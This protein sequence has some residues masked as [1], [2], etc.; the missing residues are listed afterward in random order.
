MQLYPATGLSNKKLRETRWM[1]A[2]ESDGKRVRVTVSF[3]SHV[4]TPPLSPPST[5]RQ[6]RRRVLRVLGTLAPL[7]SLKGKFLPSW[8]LTIIVRKNHGFHSNPSFPT[9]NPH[10]YF[11][12]VVDMDMDSNLHIQVS[13][14]KVYFI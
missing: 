4:T 9:K 1:V 12:G 14:S 3:V 10:C 7:K 11:Y 2:A 6:G 13:G 8:T 5:E